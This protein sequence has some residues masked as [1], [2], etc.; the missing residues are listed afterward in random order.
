[1][2]R[3]IVAPNPG[4]YTLDGTCSYVVG[5]DVIIDP[6]P[7]IESH[8][9]AL[10]AAAPAVRRIFITHRHADH[11]PAAEPL[12]ERTG[13]LVYAPRGA[14]SQPDQLVSGGERIAFDGEGLEV[15]ATPGHTREHVCFL[16]GNG[17]LF[18]GDTVLGAGTT[19]I[20]PPDGDMGDYLASLRKLRARSPRIIYPGHGPARADA[21]A[22]IDEYIVHRQQREQQIAG[23]V[24]KGATKITQV[25]KA[26]YPQLDDRL[27]SAAESQIE[28]HLIHLERQGRVRRGEDEWFPNA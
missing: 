28:A 26:V 8:I 4:A 6:G 11:A 13:A 2:I 15:I 7:A 19:A 22:L 25:R 9:E 3:T 10:L 12:R 16:T 18:T 14:V 20:F 1:M 21:V 27:A 23:A 24:A 17:D 5:S